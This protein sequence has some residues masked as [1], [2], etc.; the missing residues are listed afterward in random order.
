MAE[1]ILLALAVCVGAA[2]GWLAGRRS[3]RKPSGRYMRVQTTGNLMVVTRQG[4]TETSTALPE[5][6]PICDAKS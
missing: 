3:L 2:V 1:L 4:G 5:Y 6:P